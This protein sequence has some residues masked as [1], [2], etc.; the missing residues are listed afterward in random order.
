[1]L[2]SRRR[3]FWL[4]ALCPVLG[5][6]LA[7]ALMYA[8]GALLAGPV[9]EPLVAWLGL[10]DGYHAVVDKVREAGFPAL[11]LA[12][13]TPFPFQF[14]IA[15]AGAAGLSPG[16]LFLAVVVARSVRYLALGVLVRVIGE[17]ARGWIDRHQLE[18]FIGGLA[19]F[20]V[21]AVALVLG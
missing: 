2:A 1:M 8:A 12:L 4:L 5:N 9:V 17:R 3:G 7:A 13:I 21:F 16:L 6:L 14:E 15:A 10:A 19:L 11:F 18:I 20:A